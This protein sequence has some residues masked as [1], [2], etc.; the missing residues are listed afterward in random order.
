MPD[1]PADKPV[2]TKPPL[3]EHIF[4]ATKLTELAL[5]WKELTAKGRHKEAMPIL[6]EIVV[7]STAMFERLAQ[8]EDF[9]RTVELPV[10]I[11]AAQEKV[12]NWL[13]YWKPK[14]GK[15][16]SWFSKCAKNAFR[17]E[18][19]KTVQFR[20]RVHVTSDNLEKFYGF[21]EHEVD[22]HDAYEALNQK[23]KQLTCRWGDPQEIGAL[24]YLIACVLEENHSR[25]ASIRAAAYAYGLSLEQA[26]FF[27]NWALVA[28]RNELYQQAYVPLT[29]QDL[30]VQ[31]YSYTL[32][33]DLLNIITW[34]QLKKIIAVFGG[35]RLKI[36]TLAQLAQ[37][38]EDYETFRDIERSNLD[39]D[40]IAA[41]AKKRKR[42]VRTAQEAYEQMVSILDPKRAGEF[43]IYD[44]EHDDEHD[45]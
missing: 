26:K 41:I 42:S 22:R 14:K 31:A 34:D 36:P 38:K 17:S 8:F 3:G 16:F 10:L 7:E 40:S 18:V 20:R 2:D 11:S 23:L 12:V 30:F 45:D 9:H 6:E 37:I 39:P 32:L 35:K 43:Y 29:E 4:P 1:K 25:N 5:R 44:D 27:Y 24:R 13:L 21:E 33:P 28:L 15:L 19:A